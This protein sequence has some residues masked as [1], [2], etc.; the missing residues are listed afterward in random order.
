MRRPAD[1]GYRGADYDFISAPV[2]RTEG[3]LEEIVYTV[4][5]RRARS[6]VRP[7][8]MQVRLVRNLV[9]TASN[10]TN[11]DAAIGR[12][13]F[14]LLIPGRSRTVHGQQLGDGARAR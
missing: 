5:S 1:G 2:L 10:N 9:T 7:Q 8:P 4:N 11:T 14:N 6:E 13:L 12:T 3:E